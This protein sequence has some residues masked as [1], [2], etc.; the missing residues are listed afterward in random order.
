[1]LRWLLVPCRPVVDSRCLRGGER[2]EAKISDVEAVIMDTTILEKVVKR[3][4]Y[5]LFCF[6]N[7][8]IEREKKCPRWPRPPR[9]CRNYFKLT[10]PDR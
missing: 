4:R 5:A 9:R 8:K 6:V 2:R 3:M 1:M 10:L 7:G